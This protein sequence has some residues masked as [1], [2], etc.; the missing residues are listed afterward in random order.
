[1]GGIE[2]KPTHHRVGVIVRMLHPGL[3]ERREICVVS[4]EDGIR[5]LEL[6]ELHQQALLT[7][8]DAQRIDALLGLQLIGRQKIIGYRRIPEIDKHVMQRRST[9]ATT[10]W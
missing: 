6:L 3:G 5:G 1:M 9:T 8:I 7:H 4:V 2:T 10:R